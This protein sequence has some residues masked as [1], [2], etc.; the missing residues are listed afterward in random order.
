MTDMERPMDSDGE[1]HWDEGTIHAWLDGALDEPTSAALERHIAGCAECAARVAEARGLIAGASR[2]VRALD[3]LPSGTAPAWGGGPVVGPPAEGSTWRLLRVTPARATIAATLLVALGV[4]LTHRRTGPDTVPATAMSGAAAALPPRTNAAAMPARDPLLDS[5][6]ARNLAAVQPPRHLEP[7]ASQAVPTP[8]PLPSPAS[9]PDTTARLRV[10][11]GRATVQVQR[12][13]T[14]AVADRARV[15]SD[16]RAP[17][18][19]LPADRALAAAVAAESAGS[20]AAGVPSTVLRA[21]APGVVVAPTTPGECYRVE[22]AN[23]TAA[24]WGS[25]QLPLVVMLDG[26]GGARITTVDG[27]ETDERATYVRGGGDSLTLRLRRIGYQGSITLG[28][29]GEVRA[30]VMRSA[31]QQLA[32][33]EVVVSSAGT[34]TQRNRAKSAPESAGDPLSMAPSVPIV[35]RS[36]RCSAP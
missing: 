24:A 18:T 14:S 35:A 1:R 26:P 4:T 9:L 8:A 30:G 25:V 3:D 27:K 20:A 22:S 29:A 15:G 19:A 7:A 23:G 11:V 6:I 16:G 21:R 34:D 36:V 33:S 10:A 32:L 17:G 13:T 28:A 12:D 2:V 5:A 31:P